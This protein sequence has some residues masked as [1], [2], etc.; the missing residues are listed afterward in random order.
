MRIGSLVI[1][2]EKAG[3]ISEGPLWI[4][5]HSCWMY[6]GESFLKLLYNIVKFWKSDR[7][8]IG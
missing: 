7:N 5:F 6:T 2:K 3:V 1:F 4:C 8:I